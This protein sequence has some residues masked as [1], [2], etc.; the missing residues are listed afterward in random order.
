MPNW[1]KNIVEFKNMEKEDFLMFLEGVRKDGEVLGS[2]DFEK[3]IP[4]P[5]NIYRGMMGQKEVALYGKNNLLDWAVENW[6]TKWNSRDYKEVD[7]ENLQSHCVEFLTAWSCPVQIMEQLSKV[8]PEQEVSFAWADED[9]GYNV[10]K[11]ILK[12]RCCVF[13]DVPFIGEKAI[14]MAREIWGIKEEEE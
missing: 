11:V 10:G 6:G 1:V 12:D 7:P 14:K 13:E 9:I 8:Y 4:P 5:P 2:V 3:I